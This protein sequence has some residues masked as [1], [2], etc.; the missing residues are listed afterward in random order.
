MANRKERS[1]LERQP[2]VHQ[3]PAGAPAH[4]HEHEHAHHPMHQ[5]HFDDM[6][7][8]KDAS[9]FGMWVFLIQEI[10]FFGGLF[11]AYLVYRHKFY[12]AFGAASSTLDITLG[13]VNTAVLIGSS[14]TM[15]MAVNSAQLGKRMRLIF[16]ML[17]TMFLGTIFL[18]VKV[19]EY[20][21]KWE[22]REIPGASFCFE[23]QGARCSGVSE[24]QEKE[25]WNE[26]IP[27]YL[28][29]G[30]GHP[31]VDEAENTAG[32]PNQHMPVREGAAHGPTAPAEAGAG[33][34]SADPDL[35]ES[36]GATE[37]QRSMPGAEIYFDLYF[38]MTGM[39]A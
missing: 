34:A 27:R 16:F 31:P 30:W 9:S 2:N 28:T 38:A 18:G 32:Q 7:Q 35:A 8:Q 36:V 4:P 39:H 24:K 17:A 21:Q 1:R 29:G 19:V 22:K 13:T 33:Q 11:V 6:E 25:K 5:H 10:M 12:G 23:P 14:L 20:S 26:V 37:R 3:H 15:A